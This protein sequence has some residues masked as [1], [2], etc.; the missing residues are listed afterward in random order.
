MA[1]GK[2]RRPTDQNWMQKISWQGTA[3]AQR[4]RRPGGGAGS[5]ASSQNGVENMQS[6]SRT[7]AGATGAR[8]P[9]QWM[10]EWAYAAKCAAEGRRA[11]GAGVLARRARPA[12]RADPAATPNRAPTSPSRGAESRSP[13]AGRMTPI[14]QGRVAMKPFKPITNAAAAVVRERSLSFWQEAVPRGGRACRCRARGGGR[15]LLRRPAFRCKADVEAFAVLNR[16]A[17]SRPS[18]A[19]S[20]ARSPAAAGILRVR[21]SRHGGGGRTAVVTRDP[22]PAAEEIALIANPTPSVGRR[23]RSSWPGSHLACRVRRSGARRRYPRRGPPAR[24]APR[25]AV[26]SGPAEPMPTFLPVSRFEAPSVSTSNF[27][28]LIPNPLRMRFDRLIHQV[29]LP[30]HPSGGC[31]PHGLRTGS[32]SR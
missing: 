21:Q 27:L 25:D 4:G 22:N 31:D 29:V 26:S 7:S 3:E 11:V 17:P 9:M 1:A 10:R 14:R 32:C 18:N 28:L 12:R 15:L 30:S 13:A 23:S 2:L 8:S 24:G 20:S 6:Q 5:A 16:K 19:C